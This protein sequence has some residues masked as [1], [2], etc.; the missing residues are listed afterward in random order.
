MV[1]K[2]YITAPFGVHIMWPFDNL[3]AIWNILALFGILHKENLATLF[4]ICQKS[5]IR[6]VSTSLDQ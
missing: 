1:I 2:K 6:R 3:V 4:L 5:G